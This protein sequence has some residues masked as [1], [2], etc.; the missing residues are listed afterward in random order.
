MSKLCCNLQRE[1]TSVIN[2]QDTIPFPASSERN[3]IKMQKAFLDHK[4]E[5]KK[6]ILLLLK[7]LSNSKTNISLVPKHNKPV[8]MSLIA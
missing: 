7:H 8:D 3:S 2:F 6:R 5:K 1:V 4:G